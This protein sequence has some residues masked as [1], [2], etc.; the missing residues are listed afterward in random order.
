MYQNYDATFM[1]G[2]RHR[3]SEGSPTKV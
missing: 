1:D 3:H 2:K